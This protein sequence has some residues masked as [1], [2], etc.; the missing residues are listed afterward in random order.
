MEFRYYDKMVEDV[1]ASLGSY[2]QSE[3]LAEAKMDGWMAYFDASTFVTRRETAKGGPTPIPISDEI[4]KTVAKFNLPK[5][6][7]LLGEWMKRRTIGE[8]PESLY[9]HDILWLDDKWMGNVQYTER[10]RILG[11]FVVPHLTDLVKLPLNSN[12]ANLSL[13]GFF[14]VMKQ[15]PITE[16]VV[17]KHLDFKIKG[18]ISKAMNNALICKIKWRSGCIGRDVV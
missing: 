11:K 5:N 1:P 6:S 7:Q 15:I 14:E 17:L 4:R 9:I 13:I 2:S 3:W 10:Q 18:G 8:C 16:G 12:A